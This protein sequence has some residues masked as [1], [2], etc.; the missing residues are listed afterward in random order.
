MTELNT[1]SPSGNGE[2]QDH[3]VNI[4]DASALDRAYRLDK[5]VDRA[6]MLIHF[7]PMGSISKQALKLI[8]RGDQQAAHHLVRRKY[9]EK[10]TVRHACPDRKREFLYYRITPKGI[11][12]ILRSGLG[13]P[14]WFYKII[15]PDAFTIWGGMSS[16][17]LLRL[18]AFQ[19][20]VAFFTMGN[21]PTILSELWNGSDQAIC[22]LVS[23]RQSIY[24]ISA[25]TVMDM[26]ISGL[27]KY[28]VAKADDPDELIYLNAL[29]NIYQGHNLNEKDISKHLSF[30]SRGIC[31]ADIKEVQYLQYLKNRTAINTTQ[32][33]RDNCIGIFSTSAQD[34]SVYITSQYGMKYAVKTAR[35][36][37]LYNSLCASLISGNPSRHMECRC[38]SAI[39]L[40]RTATEMARAVLDPYR[41]RGELNRE[42][43]SMHD[44]VY[45][46]PMEI[47]GIQMLDYLLSINPMSFAKLCQNELQDLSG[48]YEDISYQGGRLIDTVSHRS[49]VNCTSMDLKAVY[50][51]IDLLSKSIEQGSG[52]ILLCEDWQEPFFR[53]L[54]YQWEMKEHKVGG[55]THV[56]IRSIHIHRDSKNHGWNSR[57]D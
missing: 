9:I 11:T 6:K 8:T 24:D 31:Y 17:L 16:A 22:T 47:D 4:Y 14:D 34:Y 48:L 32:T 10:K 3:Y 42:L 20:A 1:R 27:L 30:P 26:L 43:G 28:R 44:H 15:V 21:I 35:S 12:Y 23:M 33:L 51:F 29:N 49:C 39:I 7:L 46:V 53:E 56:E 18:V 37:L 41:V 40:C 2:P 52:I 36:G 57:F 50:H 45:L 54:L 38:T 13:L 25:N 55:T 5:M 19:D